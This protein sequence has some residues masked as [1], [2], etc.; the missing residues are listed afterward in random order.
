MNAPLSR[1]SFRLAYEALRNDL[2]ALLSDD[3]V[4]RDE[5]RQMSAALLNELSMR[6]AGSSVPADLDR[7][8]MIRNR[9]LQA[10]V[11]SLT[12][13]FAPYD[14]AFSWIMSVQPRNPED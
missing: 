7:L 9:M 4:Y 3:V 2:G 14:E 13:D 1:W 5:F 6:R 8:L 11:A 12:Y 10:D